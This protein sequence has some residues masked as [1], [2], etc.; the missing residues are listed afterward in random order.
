MVASPKPWLVI[1][2]YGPCKFVA[3]G[4]GSFWPFNLLWFTSIKMLV[5]QCCGKQKRE[6]SCGGRGL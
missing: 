6:Q 3:K 5:D 4:L 1:Q 2:N